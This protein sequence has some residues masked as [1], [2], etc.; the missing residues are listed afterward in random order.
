MDNHTAISDSLR[1]Q[2]LA[3]E[4]NSQR[5]KDM[6]F[7]GIGSIIATYLGLSLAFIVMLNKAA[8]LLRF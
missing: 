3:I 8:T 7:A 6:P 4:E 2:R 5:I 1:N